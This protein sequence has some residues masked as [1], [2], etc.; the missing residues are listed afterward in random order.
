MPYTL[1]VPV[2]WDVIATK[3]IW[4]SAS[5]YSFWE[6]IKWAKVTQGE[7]KNVVVLLYL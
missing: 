4:A 1:L 5:F 7:K 3:G 2:I 6:G